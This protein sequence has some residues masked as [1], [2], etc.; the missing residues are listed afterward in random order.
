MEAKAV[1]TAEQRQQLEEL[2]Q[3]EAQEQASIKEERK[4]L[5]EMTDETVKDAFVVLEQTS[6]IITEAKAKV[7]GM[8]ADI[9]ELKKQVYEGSDDQFSH[10]FT[11]KDGMLR[12]IIGFHVVDHFDD[13][14]TAGVDG[15]NK[16]LNSLGVDENSK[17][18]VKMAKKLLSRDAQGT[19]NARKVMQLMQMANESGKTE[20]INNVQIIIDAY[21]PIKTKLFIIARYRSENEKKWVTLPLGITEAN[22]D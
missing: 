11:S 2:K 21:K 22:I 3:L 10:T 5:K 7:Y 12:I 6:K 18:L 9:I 4:A 17:M 15:V 14:H 20:F 8:F 1:M 13:S 19:L 16:F